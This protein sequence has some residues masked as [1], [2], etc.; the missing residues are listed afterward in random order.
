MTIVNMKKVLCV[1]MICVDVI[2]VCDGYP[3]EDSEQRATD[4][5]LERGGNAS[6]S[7]TV[8]S[9][10]GTPCECL[11]TMASGPF[12]QF[13]EK[14]FERYN[15]DIQHCRIYEGSEP[16]IATIVINGRNGSRTIIVSNKGLPEPFL[17]D[18]KKVNLQDYSWIHFEGRNVVEVEKMVNYIKKEMPSMK[19]SLELEKPRQGLLNLAAVVD[20][21]LV[22]KDFSIPLGWNDMSSTLD[23]MKTLV[24]PSAIVISTWGEKGATGL[25][26][27]GEK[28]HCPAYSPER[29]VDTIGA[30]DTFNAAIIHAMNRNLTLKG[31][32]DFACRVA[33]CKVGLEGFNGLERFTESRINTF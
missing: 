20:L 2:Q 30:G 29:V 15:I 31:A 14:S 9:L 6:N 11:G 33:G 26:P 22:G 8:L 5:R 24:K 1:G 12:L 17:A 23:H 28:I 7:S 25:G 32:L 10:L 16:V 3:E 4:F 21:V 18:F 27:D 19:I 13:L